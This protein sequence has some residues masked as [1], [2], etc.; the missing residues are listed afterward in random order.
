MAIKFKGSEVS[1]ATPGSIG[2]RELAWNIP[3]RIIYTKDSSN[4]LIPFLGTDENA[5]WGQITGS[6]LAQ[7]DLVNLVE[8]REDYLGLPS[9]DGQILS[10]LTDGTRNWVDASGTTDEKVK[11]SATDSA[12]GYLEDK[13]V[14]GQGNSFDKSTGNEQLT[15]NS[16]IF[17][18]TLDSNLIPMYLDTNRN[19]TVSVETMTAVFAESRL[20]KNEW[21]S[22]GAATDAKTS[23]VMP[24]NGTIVGAFG[25]T[26]K[27]KAQTIQV[28][29]N[30]SN[31]AV[32]LTFVSTGEE[33]QID[34]SLDYTFLAGDKIRIRAGNGGTMQDT[35]IELRIKWRA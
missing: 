29:I 10:S 6:I 17:L 24:Y 20:S 23:F 15:V 28:W 27:A 33:T 26:S 13:I 5:T 32:I 18:I 8:T 35:N 14:S 3:D 21:M 4:L 16:E 31:T 25:H 12:A 2:E 9:T 34:N 1:G 11:I 19:K 7:T 30:G 22:I